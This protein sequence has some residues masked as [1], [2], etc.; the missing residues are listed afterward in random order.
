MALLLHTDTDCSSNCLSPKHHTF[1]LSRAQ[2]VSHPNT[3]L[4]SYL[5]LKLSFA[6]TPHFCL[7]SRSD[8]LSPKHHT[9]VL[10]RPQTVFRPNTHF[11]LISRSDCL[12]P[13]HPT[14]VLSRAQTVSHPN[15]TLLSY[16]ALRLCFTE[17]LHV[18]SYLALRLSRKQHI[19]SY[20]SFIQTPHFVARADS[21][22]CR[23]WDTVCEVFVFFT[24]F[25]VSV[26]NT[27]RAC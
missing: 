22:V 4:L 13:K 9:F 11:C 6:Q 27:R 1:V 3:T 24:T 19:L 10:S 23:N 17:T 18:L 2:T 26:C 5:A 7:I 16:L 15:T 25:S 14:F 8:C 12:S 21:N 20:L